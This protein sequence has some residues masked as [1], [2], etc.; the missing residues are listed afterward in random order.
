MWFVAILA[1]VLSVL[2]GVLILRRELNTA[3]RIA[4]RAGGDAEEFRRE[5]EEMNSSF[6]DIANDLE[7]KYSVHEKQIQDMQLLLSDYTKRQIEKQ[8]SG[9]KSGFVKKE[10]GDR[11][12]SLSDSESRVHESGAALLSRVHGRNAHENNAHGN[13]DANYAHETHHG[14]D[15]ANEERLI[16]PEKIKREQYI[17]S[18]AREKIASGMSVS[19]TA[20]VLGVGVGELRLILGM[21]DGK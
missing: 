12:K 3:L 14:N 5:L 4:P 21:R 13:N 6:F 1:G 19:E 16:L 15:D 8:K 10:R 17:L 7:G 20:K 2:F 9:Q 11:K 18:E